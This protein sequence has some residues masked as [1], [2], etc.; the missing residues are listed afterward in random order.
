MVM[1]ADSIDI[2][3]MNL[4]IS[5]VGVLLSFWV[6]NYR[7]EMAATKYAQSETKR[8]EHE[9]ILITNP[10]NQLKTY[11]YDITNILINRSQNID[12][13]KLKSP[14]AEF[15]YEHLKTGYPKLMQTIN[16]YEDSYNRIANQVNSIYQSASDLLE[17]KWKHD[18]D[19]NI[20]V[21]QLKS[22]INQ[23]IA[24]FSGEVAH[25]LINN[26][27]PKLSSIHP[28]DS[29]TII[30]GSSHIIIYSF[31]DRETVVNDLNLILEG[32]EVFGKLQQLWEKSKSLSEVRSQIHYEL[33]LM[34]SLVYAGVT[35]KGSCVACIKAH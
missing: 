1:T 34:K 21:H 10:I 8:R 35:L 4:L 13:H 14:D 3:I 5:L 22:H 26:T 12:I 31:I 19:L 7:G 33:E 15:F 32:S 30:V 11:L 24:H 28:N 6:A 27:K 29:D 16:R 17:K 25:R 9:R 20:K 2:L 23:I 18:P